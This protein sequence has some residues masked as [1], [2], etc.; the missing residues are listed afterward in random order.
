MEKVLFITW[1]NHP[2][3]RNALSNIKEFHDSIGHITNWS[4]FNSPNLNKEIEYNDVFYIW[5]GSYPFIQSKIIK[6]IRQLKKKIIFVEVAW[7]PQGDFL[8]FDEKGTNG[9]CSLFSDDLSW[10]TDE[11]FDRAK[12]L[13]KAYRGGRELRDLD[14]IFCPM[15]L[16]SDMQVALWSPCKSMG[17]LVRRARK[18]NAGKKIIFRKH[19]KDGGNY[20]DLDLGLGGDG[21]LKDLICNSSFVYGINSTVLLEAALMGKKVVSIGKSLLDI[22]PN[23]EYSLAALVARQVPIGTKDFTPWMREGRG[24]NFL[25]KY[26]D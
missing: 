16:S 11:D 25:R 9:N 6:R 3:A 13:G 2:W 4:N 19:P 23:T 15:Q 22:H 10:L 18:E 20:S 17:E 8:Y 21:D 24:L 5:N 7:F 1:Q 12:L 14:Y 26:L